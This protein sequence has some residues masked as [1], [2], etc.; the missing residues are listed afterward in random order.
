MC[1]CRMVNS[2]SLSSP[3]RSFSEEMPASLAI[4]RVTSWVLL[5]SRLN[6]ATA[7]L[8]ST[9]MLR[10]MLSTKAVLPMPGRAATMI[11]SLFCQPAVILSRRVNPVGTPLTPPVRFFAFSM[12]A[13]ASWIR[14]LIGS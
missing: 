10:A 3:F 6:T 11:M 1:W 7:R 4:R 14:S 13:M 2:A 12:L 9:A 8:C 5:I